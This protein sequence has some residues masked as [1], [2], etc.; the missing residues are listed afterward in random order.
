MVSNHIFRGPGGE[1]MRNDT[2]YHRIIPNHSIV[3]VYT[4]DCG[5]RRISS[6]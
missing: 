4:M 5:D 1:L 6:S 2:R 3:F